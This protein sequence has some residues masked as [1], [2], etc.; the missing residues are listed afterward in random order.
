[1]L[2][3]YEHERRSSQNTGESTRGGELR[4]FQEEH[5]VYQ[6]KL[7]DAKEDLQRRINELNAH[8]QVGDAFQS[9]DSLDQ[10]PTVKVAAGVVVSAATTLVLGQAA[11]GGKIVVGR[12]ARLTG[13]TSLELHDDLVPVNF[14]TKNV[15]CV[16]G[17]GMDLRSSGVLVVLSGVTIRSRCERVS[18]NIGDVDLK[19]SIDLSGQPLQLTVPKRGHSIGLGNTPKDMHISS[20]ELQRMTSQGG[21]VV[22]SSGGVIMVDGVQK[23]HSKGLDGQIILRASGFGSSIVFN[24]EPSVFPS[25]IA[26]SDGGIEVNQNITTTKG[27]LQFGQ[28]QTMDDDEVRSSTLVSLDSGVALMA[29]D[30]L[31][32]HPH[33]SQAQGA[34]AFKGALLLRSTT[35]GG[36]SLA[37]GLRANG[38][39]GD[40]AIDA[41]EGILTIP[42]GSHVDS[43]SHAIQITA[44]DIDLQGTLQSGKAGV[45]VHGGKAGQ[46]MAIG[47]TAPPEINGVFHEGHSTVFRRKPVEMYLSDM[48]RTKQW[49]CAD[50]LVQELGRMHSGGLTVGSSTSG[51]VHIDQISEGSAETSGLL[52]LVAT[53]PGSKVTHESSQAHGRVAGDLR[54][55]LKHFNAASWAVC[56]CR[57]CNHRWA[58]HHSR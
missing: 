46:G 54:A 3:G 18:L 20:D 39:G 30:G 4:L 36:I 5:Q 47:G 6:K 12:G 49:Q 8:S 51:D 26:Q 35:R 2:T 29:H 52:K 57:W 41:G 50:Y 43:N 33:K 42:S 25:L 19:G 40:V 15:P 21:L 56:G 16:S 24:S 11:D 37:G 13:G 44:L 22:D 38:L 1:M 58:Q 31:S 17:V 53:A 23:A 48:V 27:A 14:N 7:F 34:A 28:T 32:I 9:S 45:R 55:G 10:T